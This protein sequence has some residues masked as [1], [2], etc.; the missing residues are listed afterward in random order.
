M[1]D[2]RC[3]SECFLYTRHSVHYRTLHELA[4]EP[5]LENYNLLFAVVE[6]QN[7][8]FLLKRISE[9]WTEGVKERKHCFL[10]FY[11]ICILSG[12]AEK[13][14]PAHSVIVSWNPND[15]TA[16]EKWL[17][18]SCQSHGPSQSQG[19]VSS[20]TRK[21]RIVLSSECVVLPCSKRCGWLVGFSVEIFKNRMCTMCPFHHL[22]T[23][24]FDK[25]N[26]PLHD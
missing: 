7:A 12:F 11:T 8:T 4:V 5:D 16:K 17:S 18:L 1:P 19:S 15:A 21:R 25:H 10:L 22:T 24:C 3:L 23:G 2:S 26:P 13:R 20:C 6:A 9:P 14:S